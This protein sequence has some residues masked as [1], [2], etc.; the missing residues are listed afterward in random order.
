LIHFTKRYLKN[1]LYEYWIGNTL[2]EKMTDSKQETTVI[3]STQKFECSICGLDSMD[4]VQLT[5]HYLSHSLIQLAEALTKLQVELFTRP[6]EIYDDELSDDKTHF[7]KQDQN[8]IDET[9]RSPL[10]ST[11]PNIQEKSNKETIRSYSCDICQKVLSSKGT[12]SKHKLLHSGEKPHQCHLCPAQFIQRRSL[13]C[14]VMQKHSLER[15]YKC[16]ICNKGF[17][18]SFYLE[19]HMAYHSGEKKHQCSEC[20]K[21]FS[22]LGALT[23]HSKRHSTS[24]SFSC[25]LCT[26]SFKVIVDLKTHIKFVHAKDKQIRPRESHKRK[27]NPIGNKSDNNQASINIPTK[28]IKLKSRKLNSTKELLQ[29]AKENDDGLMKMSSAVQRDITTIQFN[30][31]TKEN[32]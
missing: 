29:L 7:Q 16:K 10:N 19:E 17:V 11:V 2:F 20:G 24:K 15:P 21:R 27:A 5:C 3:E 32:D 31:E 18:Y 28:K 4:S 23:K 12:L 9:E 8:T 1:V 6:F 30:I 13:T 25:D 14:H 22:S 26:K